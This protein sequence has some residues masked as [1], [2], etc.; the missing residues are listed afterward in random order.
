MGPNGL[1]VPTRNALGEPQ[2]EIGLG[3]HRIQP[4]GGA[5]GLG[6]LRVPAEPYQGLAE[7]FVDHPVVGMAPQAPSVGLLGVAPELHV[8]EGV[9]EHLERG[10][11][12]R[13]VIDGSLEIGPG[14]FQPVGVGLPPFQAVSP[15]VVVVVRHHLIVAQDHRHGKGCRTEARDDQSGRP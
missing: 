7:Q 5:K 3:E 2:A 6:C 11:G 14:A 12:V 8:S 9:P 13:P 4:H 10:E 15:L 1:L